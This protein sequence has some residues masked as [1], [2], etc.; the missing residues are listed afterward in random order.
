M[1][2]LGLFRPCFISWRRAVQ[3]SGLVTAAGRPVTFGFGGQ[4]SGCG[5]P[6]VACRLNIAQGHLSV[7][8]TKKWIYG[9]VGGSTAENCTTR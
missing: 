8:L 7:Q 9:A 6:M 3:C 5:E 4:R 2:V 1:E